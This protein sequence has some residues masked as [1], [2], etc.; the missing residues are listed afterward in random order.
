LGEFTHRAQLLKTRGTFIA[1]ARV[2]RFFLSDLSDVQTLSLPNHNARGQINFSPIPQ[3][4]GSGYGQALRSSQLNHM[5]LL[6]DGLRMNNNLVAA[7][8][9]LDA[10]IAE[11]K[12]AEA[13]CMLFRQLVDQSN[14]GIFI[15]QA[16][17]ARILDVNEAAC[18]Q[19]GYSRDELLNL[20]ILDIST[21]VTNWQIWEQS[22]AELQT[23]TSK[24]A[25][26]QGKRKDGS[27]LPFEISLRYVSFYEQNYILAVTRDV[28]ER[29]SAA[30][31]LQRL[32]AAVEQ[33]ADSIVIT[34]L[35]GHIEYVNPAFER[36]TGYTREEAVGANPRILKSGQTD[37]ATYRDLWQTITAGGVWVGRLVNK[38][39]DGTYFTERATISAVRD[40]S[41]EIAHYIA[42][43][44]DTT[45]ETQL[46]EQLRQSQKMEAVGQLAG[47][48]AHDFNNLLTAINGYAALLLRRVSDDSPIKSQLEEIKKAGERAAN[49]TRQLLAFGRKQMLHPLSLNL[50]DNVSDLTKMLKRLIGEDIQ[51]ITKLDPRLARTKADP[52]QIEQVVMNLVVNARDAM[53]SGGVITI[54]TANAE[55]NDAYA[56]SHVGVLAGSYVMLTVSD[57]GTGMDHETLSHIFEPFFTTKAKNKG[58][59]LG[60][61][62]VYGIMKQSGGS[63]WVYSEVGIGTTFKLFL[64]QLSDEPAGAAVIQEAP[65]QRGSETVLLVEDEGLVRNLT[66]QLLRENGYRVLSA[67]GGEEALQIARSNQD[68]ELLLTDVVMPKMSGREVANALKESHPKTRVLYMSGY[69][70]DAIVHHGIADS[71]IALLHKPFSEKA[72]TQKIRDV[73]DGEMKVAE[74]S[75]H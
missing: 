60:L 69:T 55:L 48:V 2:G 16:E 67:C 30:A 17:T 53:P 12:R 58:T 31:E 50:N 57:T 39:K 59:G 13:N 7:A 52:G 61:S 42:V 11:R 73:L 25:D 74:G 71:R 41:G 49:L 24:V 54:E 56:A 65:I 27:T 8:Q 14:D 6:E 35:N 4:Q 19:L 1:V 72:L 21:E 45:H 33:T 26:Y 18:R 5:N 37:A 70:D 32:A 3:Q 23:V 36:I 63:I 9:L 29:K 43:K 64:P 66:I 62:T 40:P 51:L 44:Q 38:K 68:I 47:G 10:E 20:R 22:L 15:V 34:D 28:T 46:E 75:I